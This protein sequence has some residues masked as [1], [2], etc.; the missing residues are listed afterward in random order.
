[1]IRDGDGLKHTI[2]LQTPH[3]PLTHRLAGSSKLRV[4]KAFILSLSLFAVLAT[5]LAVAP[6][7]NSYVAHEWGTFTSVQGK[8]GVQMIWNPRI[9]V[10]L[11]KFVHNAMSDPLIASFTKDAF[12]GRQ[13][14][15][16]PVIYFYADRPQ[17]VDV[18]VDFPGGTITEWFPQSA[19]RMEKMAGK[20]FATPRPPGI[21]WDKVN[22]LTSKTPDLLPMDESGSHYFAAR[23]TDANLVQVAPENGK[24]ETEKFLFYRGVGDFTAPLAVKLESTDFRTLR[25]ENHGT[26]NI[27][28]FYVLENTPVRRGW[29]KIDNL[30]PNETRPLSLTNMTSVESSEALMTAMASQVSQTLVKQGLFPREASA[31]VKTWEQTWFN[32]PGLRVLYPMSRGNTDKVLP[33]QLSPAP[34][35]LV[36]VMIGRAEI[37][38][39]VVEQ[40][41]ADATRRY[42]LAKDDEATRAKIVEEVHA[43]GFGRFAD[44]ILRRVSTDPE[45]EKEFVG[46]GDAPLRL[47]NEVS[48]LDEK[49]P[50]VVAKQGR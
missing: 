7:S 34:A 49:K 4:M 45:R 35:K 37:I 39:P 22:V 30:K 20:K 15:E 18:S 38:T 42:V 26:E 33:L 19:Q 10:E 8:D 46:Y 17:T 9:A 40:Q 27:A 24:A 31:M 25:V 1:M 5:V 21:S 23:D 36:R 2:L 47:L 48:K 11:P 28:E 16:T 12:R 32:E 44:S 13:R 3:R 29:L 50:A 6:N 41:L 14:M 43:F